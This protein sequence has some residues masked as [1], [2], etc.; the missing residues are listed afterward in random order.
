[1]LNL[2]IQCTTITGFF[3]YYSETVFISSLRHFENKI[4]RAS[5]VMPSDYS[6][7]KRSLTKHLN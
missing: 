4:C 2:S 5:G 6:T 3:V 1:M 7:N